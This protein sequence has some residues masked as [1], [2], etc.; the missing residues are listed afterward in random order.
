MAQNR[1]HNSFVMYKNWG[2]L[3][4]PLDVNQKAFILDAIFNFQCNGIKPN[5][6]DGAVNMLLTIMMQV[7]I[8]N[9]EKYKEQCERNKRNGAKGG[10]PRKDSTVSY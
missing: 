4:K 7:F 8:E 9:E 1:K 2:E 3:I 10:R 6:D 5:T